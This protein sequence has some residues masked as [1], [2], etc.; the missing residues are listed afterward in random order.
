MQEGR[1]DPKGNKMSVTKHG[2]PT[3]ILKWRHGGTD[4]MACEGCVA[5]PVHLAS[6]VVEYTYICR[7]SPYMYAVGSP[8]TDKC[9]FNIN[10]KYRYY[11]VHTLCVSIP[12]NG[13]GALLCCIAAAM[14]IIINHLPLI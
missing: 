10:T 9:N 2:S 6:V 3:E 7:Y 5:K 12:Y 14:P 8:F 11:V 4:R 13:C 1:G